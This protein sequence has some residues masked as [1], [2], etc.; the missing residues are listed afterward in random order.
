MLDFT[1]TKRTNITEGSIE[2][3]PWEFY[4]NVTKDMG[5]DAI[6][7][8]QKEYNSRLMLHG[9]DERDKITEDGKMGPQTWDAISQEGYKAKDIEQIVTNRAIQKAN[10]DRFAGWVEAR[11]RQMETENKRKR[12]E[13]QKRERAHKP[14]DYGA[15]KKWIWQKEQENKHKLAKKH[16]KTA[17]TIASGKKTAA[18]AQADYFAGR[19]GTK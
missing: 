7:R 17:G 8:I 5:T 18:Q 14:I 3:A 19:Y 9:G 11:S 2:D 1:A 10:A 4:K 6:K 13:Q 15:V 12:E 16:T